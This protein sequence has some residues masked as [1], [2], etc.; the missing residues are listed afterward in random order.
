LECLFGTDA[1]LTFNCQDGVAEARV[2]L[3]A[4][5]AVETTSQT[6]AE[7]EVRHASVSR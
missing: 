5:P 3:P 7:P 2:E 1:S 4:L 6:A